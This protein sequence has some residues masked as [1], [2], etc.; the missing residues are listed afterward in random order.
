MEW[1]GNILKNKMSLNIIYKFC[2][3]NVKLQRVIT[4]FKIDL[5]TKA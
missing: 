5:F 4:L 2:C 1:W 3:T